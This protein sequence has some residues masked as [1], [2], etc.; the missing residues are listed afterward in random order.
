MP[1]SGRTIRNVGSYRNVKQTIFKVFQNLRYQ[2]GLYFQRLKLP[3]SKTALIRKNPL[4]TSDK[5]I[6]KDFTSRFSWRLSEFCIQP[7]L[8]DKT[9]RTTQ[10]FSPLPLRPKGANLFQATA[11]LIF[12][13]NFSRFVIRPTAT[14]LIL[15]MPQ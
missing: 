11:C 8:F 1:Y 12:S 6:L 4:T 2:A 3:E 13:S 7:C 15:W 9:T 14:L 5:P 10:N